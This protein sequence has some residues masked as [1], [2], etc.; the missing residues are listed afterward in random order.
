MPCTNAVLHKV[1]YC[2][3]VLNARFFG[4]LLRD[5]NNGSFAERG[6]H[7]HNCRIRKTGAVN[8]HHHPGRLVEHTAQSYNCYQ[9]ISQSVQKAHS[10]GRCFQFFVLHS[11][12][13]IHNSGK[14]M[15]NQKMTNEIDFRDSDGCE[16]KNAQI[17]RNERPVKNGLSANHVSCHGKIVNQQFDS[18]DSQ[19]KTQKRRNEIKS[20][21]RILYQNPAAQQH[22]QTGN[23]FSDPLN[24]IHASFPFLT[25]L[26]ALQNHGFHR[27]HVSDNPS[28]NRPA[29]FRM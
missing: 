18:R 14:T 22:K 4:Q 29:D 6:N 10:P 25:F 19:R 24:T 9:Q 3:Q 20:I 12:E 21:F 26:P 15:R 13:H 27:S 7:L 23:K 8:I 16:G 5:I 2:P 11:P 28:R 1:F 17:Y